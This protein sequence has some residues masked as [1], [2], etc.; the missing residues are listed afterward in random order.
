MHM[1][2]GESVLRAWCEA[3]A[4]A[5]GGTPHRRVLPFQQQRKT[6]GGMLRIP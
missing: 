2:F 6:K 3:T 5:C 1:S 4:L